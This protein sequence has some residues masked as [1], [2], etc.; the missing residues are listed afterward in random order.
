MYKV[1]IIIILSY[2]SLYFELNAFHGNVHQGNT[3][4]NNFKEDLVFKGT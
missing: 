2:F 1:S 4:K 3:K